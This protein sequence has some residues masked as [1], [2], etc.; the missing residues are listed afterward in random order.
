MAGVLLKSLAL[1][2]DDGLGDGVVHLVNGVFASGKQQVKKRR[3][4]ALG[5]EDQ[6]DSAGGDAPTQIDLNG[7]AFGGIVQ[8]WVPAGGVIAIHDQQRV[9]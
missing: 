6:L 4:R 5:I 1:A 7:P 3:R 2:V 9:S 8:M